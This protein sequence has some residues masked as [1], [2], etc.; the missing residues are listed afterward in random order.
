MQWPLNRIARQDTSIS[1]DAEVMPHP[2]SG[3]ARSPGDNLEF[4]EFAPLAICIESSLRRGLSGPAGTRIALN[5]MP[6]AA[7]HVEFRQAG[8]TAG[9]ASALSRISREQPLPA[10]TR[11]ADAIPPARRPARWV[12]QALPRRRV[13]SPRRPSRPSSA[14]ISAVA[15]PPRTGIASG[16]EFAEPRS[17]TL[18]GLEG[19]L[20]WMSNVAE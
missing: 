8:C 10:A 19:A 14:A 17:E 5:R 3:R 16:D 7:C 12:G 4:P 9:P 18:S 20:L 15:Q 6:A 2:A 13:P 11:A 1:A